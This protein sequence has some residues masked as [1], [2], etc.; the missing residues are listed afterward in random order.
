M[1]TETYL[2]SRGEARG[3]QRGSTVERRTPEPIDIALRCRK[4]REGA[5]GSAHAE[6][7]QGQRR[8]RRAEHCSWELIRVG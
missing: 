2:S 8:D 3:W 6:K 7:R 1:V 5:S 4:A